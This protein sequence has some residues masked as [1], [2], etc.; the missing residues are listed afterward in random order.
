MTSQRLVDR[1]TVGFGIRQVDK[2]NGFP[3]GNG[4]SKDW[5]GSIAWFGNDQIGCGF[6]GSFSRLINTQITANVFR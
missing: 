3:I 1:P 6:S 5:V 2:Q 4:F